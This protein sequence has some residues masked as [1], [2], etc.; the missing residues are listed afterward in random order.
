MTIVRLI[1]FHKYFYECD[2]TA[3]LPFYVPVY[4]H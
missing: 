1:D 2:E 3:N 4:A